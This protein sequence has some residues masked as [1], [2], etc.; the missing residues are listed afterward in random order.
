MGQVAFQGVSLHQAPQ[1]LV[2]GTPNHFKKFTPM[3]DIVHFEVVS[4]CDGIYLVDAK[5]Y[6]ADATLVAAAG[7]AE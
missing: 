4:L 6:A 2:E 5:A 3:I 7:T 1:T